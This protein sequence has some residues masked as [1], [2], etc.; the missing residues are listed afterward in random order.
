MPS[1]WV[2]F[3]LQLMTSS[4]LRGENVNF[5]RVKALAQTAL[6]NLLCSSGNFDIGATD[7]ETV[8]MGDIATGHFLYIE[9]N[10]DGIGFTMASGTLTQV[11][12]RVT[13]E[14][15]FALLMTE[16]TGLTVTAG[17]NAGRVTYCILGAV[18]GV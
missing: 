12:K 4:D 5:K 11:A 16:F 18:S 1:Q 2:T 13:N 3:G 6:T 7:T 10:V 15:A 9:T 14:N 17:A 8:P